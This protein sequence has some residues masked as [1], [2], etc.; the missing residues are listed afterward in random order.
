MTDGL[1]PT[2]RHPLIPVAPPE[3]DWLECRFCEA[4]ADHACVAS[5]EVDGAHLRLFV[6]VRGGPVLARTEL[7]GDVEVEV[8]ACAR[9]G[10]TDEHGCVDGCGW[11]HQEGFVRVLDVR[12]IVEGLG[13]DVDALVSALDRVDVPTVLV[14]VGLPVCSIC[15]ARAPEYP[16]EVGADEVAA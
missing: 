3:E 2:H 13:V 5:V 11:A 1:T 8:N 4:W 14:N 12:A 10:C 6:L 7:D 15:A 9:C 16:W